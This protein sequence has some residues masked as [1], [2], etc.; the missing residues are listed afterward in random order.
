MGLA[1]TFTPGGGLAVTLDG[2]PISDGP[3]LLVEVARQPFTTLADPA[4]EATDGRLAVRGLL[5]G[6]SV[7]ADWTATRVTD[8]TWE[9]AVELR[10]DGAAP[11]AITRMDPVSLVL[12]GDHWQT[13]W[14]RSAWGDEFRPQHGSTRHDTVLEVRSGRS[15]HGMSP[16]LGLETEE[17]GAD[18]GRSH[19]SDATDRL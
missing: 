19:D 3:L 7:H 13:H 12:A 15:S 1:F 2:L 17:P 16:W 11:V 14:Y 9:L 8:G 4:V 5:A 6:T 10:N 18:G